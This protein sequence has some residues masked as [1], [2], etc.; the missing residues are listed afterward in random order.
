MKNV[1]EISV[2]TVCSCSP[3][4]PGRG[5]DQVGPDPDATTASAKVGQEQLQLMLFPDP[6]ALSGELRGKS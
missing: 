3:P 1:L 5:F 2:N 4:N 6:E